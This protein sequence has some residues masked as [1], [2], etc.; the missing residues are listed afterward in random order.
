[1]TSRPEDAGVIRKE[2][3]QVR[4]RFYG[5]NWPPSKPKG[6]TPVNT[7]LGD[8]TLD[9]SHEAIEVAVRRPNVHVGVV[10][11]PQVAEQLDVVLI[12]A[13]REPKADNVVDRLGV[14]LDG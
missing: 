10:T 6:N 12:D 4:C 7:Y 2:S 11:H 14:L 13:L 3:P 9:I 8:M 5:M 1:M